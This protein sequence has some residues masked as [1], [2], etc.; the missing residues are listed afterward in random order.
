MVSSFAVWSTF[1]AFRVGGAGLQGKAFAEVCQINVTHF[2]TNMLAF[3]LA[4]AIK[5]F[6]RNFYLV[7]MDPFSAPHGKGES[8][9]KNKRKEP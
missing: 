7:R 6:Y 5:L 3:F 1:T 8:N 9:E 4:G 2:I